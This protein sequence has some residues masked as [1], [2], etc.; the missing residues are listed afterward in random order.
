MPL[1][2]N[3]GFEPGVDAPTRRALYDLRRKISEVTGL[4]IVGTIPGAGPPPYNGLQ[5]GDIVIDGDGIG[6]SWDGDSW[7]NIGPIQ[8]PA[9][10]PGPPGSGGGAGSGFSFVQATMP[11]AADEGDSWFCTAIGS[12]SGT[13]WVAVSEIPG[14]PGPLNWVQFAPGSGGG[15][16]GGTQV[17]SYLHNQGVAASTWVIVHN[18]GFYPNVTVV[19]SGL[20]TVEG[21]L[22]QIDLN[23]LRLQFSAAFTGTAY[24]S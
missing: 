6:W 20:S 18:L 1:S 3:P 22:T 15:S 2:S 12:L 13:S 4:R 5:P 21:D 8:G 10:P 16:G 14:A 7:I 11:V 24:C 17:L 23:T 9:G 19:D